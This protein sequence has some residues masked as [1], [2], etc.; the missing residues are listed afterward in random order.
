MKQILAIA[1]MSVLLY[2]CTSGEDQTT[3]NTDT[4]ATQLSEPTAVMTAAGEPVPDVVKSNFEAGY[5]DMVGVNWN[6]R[7]SMYTAEFNNNG[8][9]MAVI[10]TPD[11]T[12]HAVVAAIALEYLP[13]PVMKSA[14]TIGPI[15]SARKITMNNGAVRYEVVVKDEDYFYDENGGM[16]QEEAAKEDIKRLSRKEN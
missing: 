15:T 13:E 12:R 8:L 7:D 2:S 4:M 6:W 9:D 16:I 10:Y 3:D 14:K 11:G 5:H 1:A